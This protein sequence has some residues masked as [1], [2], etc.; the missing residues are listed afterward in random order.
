LARAIQHGRFTSSSAILASDFWAKAELAVDELR[1]GG[2]ELRKQAVRFR[3]VVK[4]F[5]A[6]PEAVVGL[7]DFSCDIAEG[8]L[9]VIL[10][11]SGCGKSTSIRLVAGL[12]TPTSGS[13]I[14]NGQPVTGPVRECGMVFQAYT[15]FPWLSVL[16]NIA[17]GLRYSTDLK[18]SERREKAREFAA[19]VGLEQFE[20]ASIKTLSGGMKQRVAIASALATDPAILLMDEPFG[21]L[22][23]QTRLLMQEHLLTIVEQSNKTV[24]FVTH[25]IEE[26]LLLGDRIYVCSSRPAHVLAEIDVPF[27]HPRTHLT[28]DRRDFFEMKHQIF[29]LLRE[30]SYARRLDE[31]YEQR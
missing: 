10:G 5:P 19:I 21:A 24:I 7:Y 30:D 6:S 4:R 29:H 25:D 20:G 31:V 8:E 23:S 14:V 3:Q 9:A 17:F 15:S 12:D 22:D 28:R 2:R 11:P 27:P 16:D 1:S 13:V 26:A 18:Q